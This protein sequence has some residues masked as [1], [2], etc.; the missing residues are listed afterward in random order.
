MA[1]SHIYVCNK[2]IH[3]DSKEA[4]PD[5]ASRVVLELSL[6][7]ADFIHVSLFLNCKLETNHGPR[8]ETYSK[9]A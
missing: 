5:L 2:T 1:V 9:H 8:Y 6:S 7:Q 3:Q 4:K